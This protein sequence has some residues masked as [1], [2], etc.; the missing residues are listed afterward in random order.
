[1]RAVPLTLPPPAFFAYQ[2][3]AVF[4]RDIDFRQTFDFAGRRIDQLSS[5][6]QVL[7]CVLLALGARCSDHPALIGSSAPRTGDLGRLTRQDADLREYG[8]AREAACEALIAQALTLADEK[9]TFRV[10]SIENV[11][12]LMLLESLQRS[13]CTWP[14]L[15]GG[16]RD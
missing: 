3:A 11:A 7:C 16:V 9:G 4:H 15:S 13:A 1:M 12:A 10:A 8:R 2:S 14:N 6:N 5:P